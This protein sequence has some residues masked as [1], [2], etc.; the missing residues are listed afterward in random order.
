M[1][2]RLTELLGTFST[3][4][5]SR[6]D[7]YLR[8][9]FF[10]QSE[11][12]RQLGDFYLQYAPDFTAESFHDE[13]AFAQ[14]FPD[15]PF[16]K[17][18]INKY[19]SLLYGLV[20]EFLVHLSLSEQSEAAHGYWLT[21]YDNREL[22]QH[23]QKGLERATRNLNQSPLRNADHYFRRLRLAQ[24]EY[25]YLS[26]RDE[27]DGDIGLQR[28]N[29][30]MDI[31]FAVEKLRQ[32]G[33]MIARQR[34][35]K[36]AYKYT[37]M[38]EVQEYVAELDV[39]ENPAIR[40]YRAILRL[41]LAPEDHLL[42]E[43]CRV[44]IIALA[45]FFTRK[46]QR[47]FFTTLENMAKYCFPPAVYPTE[48][49]AL[50]Q[51][52]LQRGIL[53]PAHGIHHSLFRNIMSV[54]IHLQRY[55]W[56]KDFLAD[57]GEAIVPHA[58]GEDIRQLSEA[59]LAFYQGRAAAAIAILQ[60]ANPK[61]VYYKLAA[62]SLLARAYYHLRE[63]EVL[64]NTLNTFTKF[65][66]DQQK[67]IAPG[68]VQSYRNFINYLRRLFRIV[69]QDEAALDEFL[70][71]RP[72]RVRAILDELKQLKREMEEEGFFMGCQWLITE[73]DSLVGKA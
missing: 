31:H 50:Y 52:Q 58:F 57:Y 8:S 35:V 44:E 11:L 7:Q 27:R 73:A 67:R 41:Q 49:F 16:R 17:A 10:N 71:R 45:D 39:R 37:W 48:L 20:R 25:Q 22:E 4:E 47:E 2:R 38:E 13:G 9:P 54:A 61:D 3:E 29:E 59:E 64:E 65:I 24:L 68:K 26:K 66:H 63:L 36:V 60:T 69:S 5:R 18:R 6:L 34:A 12:L 42:Y 1:H 19:H 72:I 51:F 14:L 46:E 56:A 40:I 43:E 28:L 53:S 70:A 62:K 55:A 23:F 33:L 30:A 21:Q 32:L 15:Q